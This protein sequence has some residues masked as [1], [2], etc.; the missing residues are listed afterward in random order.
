VGLG[1]I[2]VTAPRPTSSPSPPLSPWP[3]S[4]C[5]AWA[6]SGGVGGGSLRNQLGP[7]SPIGCG[8]W[9][10]T[11]S[12]TLASEALQP[13]PSFF[14]SRGKDRV[15]R[16]SALVE[17]HPSRLCPRHWLQSRAYDLVDCS[18]LPKKYPNQ[19]TPSDE[20]AMEFLPA[21]GAGVLPHNERRR[22]SPRGLPETP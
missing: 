13:P 10:S 2:V 6:W 9:D 17:V 18:H 1:E 8:Q 3:P 4:A 20:P 7:P 16:A 14:P 11:L 15:R 5:W 12:P 19:R 21:L 22:W